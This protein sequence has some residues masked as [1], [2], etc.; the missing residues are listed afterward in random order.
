MCCATRF[1]ENLKKK[2]NNTT[3]NGKCACSVFMCVGQT[4]NSRR[5]SSRRLSGAKDVGSSA[6]HREHIILFGRKIWKY[7]G[8]LKLWN[9]SCCRKSNILAYE[10]CSRGLTGFSKKKKNIYI[11]IFVWPTTN[12]L[13]IFIRL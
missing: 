12:L 2:M 3:S 4:E 13:F 5:A 6:K 7:N 9:E 11:I 8:F 1:V 10:G